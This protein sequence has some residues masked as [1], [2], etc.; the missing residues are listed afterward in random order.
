MC[1]Y[2]CVCTW[3]ENG[4]FYTLP[5]S[6]PNTSLSWSGNVEHGDPDHMLGFHTICTSILL[7]IIT[8]TTS[9]NDLWTKLYLLFCYSDRCRFRHQPR[10]NKLF[11]PVSEV[12]E[13]NDFNNLKKCSYTSVKIPV[14]DIIWLLKYL[15]VMM[16][17]FLPAQAEYVK[18]MSSIAVSPFSSS[19]L[20]ASNVTCEK[21]GMP[22]TKQLKKTKHQKFKE[23]DLPWK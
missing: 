13:I 21:N 17:Y 11:K 2:A 3:W 4:Y 1:M 16:V 8:T 7:T 19:P 14:S 6:I 20:V 15:D 18:L 9:Q 5:L 10:I 12:H 22:S 23:W